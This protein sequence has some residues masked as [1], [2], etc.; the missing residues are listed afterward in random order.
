MYPTTLSCFDAELILTFGWTLCS[1]DRTIEGPPPVQN[2]TT[3]HK[4]DMHMHTVKF[5]TAITEF[6]HSKVVRATS[7]ARQSV[8]LK[9]ILKTVSSSY[10][11]QFH[12]KVTTKDSLVCAEVKRISKPPVLT[13]ITDLQ[14]SVKNLPIILYP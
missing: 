13:R 10:L 2:G 9:L 8:S 1:W 11:L 5:E 14:Y 12:F 3:E 7:R 4:A 6:D